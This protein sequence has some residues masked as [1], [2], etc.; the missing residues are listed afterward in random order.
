MTH[1]HFPASKPM[2]E[3]LVDLLDM[4]MGVQLALYLDKLDAKRRLQAW[5]TLTPEMRNRSIIAR[6]SARNK[7]MGKIPYEHPSNDMKEGA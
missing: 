2:E 4:M 5:A 6:I 1:F 7:A 3:R